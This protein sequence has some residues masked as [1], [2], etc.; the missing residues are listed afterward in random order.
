MSLTHDRSIA[1]AISS[2]IDR[3]AGQIFP[4]HLAAIAQTAA[5]PQTRVRKPVLRE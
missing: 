5:A 1:W 3:A 2:G 4:G